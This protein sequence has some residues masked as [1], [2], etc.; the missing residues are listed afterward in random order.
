MKNDRI[1]ARVHEAIGLDLPDEW[2]QMREAEFVP[3]EG[4]QEWESQRDFENAYSPGGTNY[5][6]LV[7]EMPLIKKA[8]FEQALTSREIASVSASARPAEKRGRRPSTAARLLERQLR[9]VDYVVR[10]SQLLNVGHVLART[11]TPRARIKWVK[12]T[13]GWNAEHPDIQY[14]PETMQKA[15]NRAIA[16]ETVSKAYFDVL[17]K[18]WQ[19]ATAPRFR[20]AVTALQSGAAGNIRAA[21]ADVAAAYHEAFSRYGD[22]FGAVMRSFGRSLDDMEPIERAAVLDA[23]QMSYQQW[24]QRFAAPQRSADEG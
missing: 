9:L 2:W 14:E 5:E 4:D 19:D 12:L 8:V 13:D 10:S 21:M 11:F 22:D 20:P 1:R 18:R 16:N 15:F 23:L 6:Q 7:R 24:Q 17:N 3:A